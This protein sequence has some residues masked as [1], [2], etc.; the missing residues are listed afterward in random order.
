MDI[1]EIEEKLGAPIGRLENCIAMFKTN[2]PDA[3]HMKCLRDLLPEI[4]SEL[5]EG[6]EVAEKLA[7]P[8][9]SS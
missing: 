5:R 2:L 8:E 4:L 9:W 6:Y 7:H 1:D 3:I